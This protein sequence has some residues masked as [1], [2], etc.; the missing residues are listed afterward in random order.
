MKGKCMLQTVTILISLFLLMACMPASK[1]E[2]ENQFSQKNKQLLFLDHKLVYWSDNALPQCK[3][4]SLN[5]YTKKMIPD[6]M[7]FKQVNNERGDLVFIAASNVRYSFAFQTGGRSYSVSVKIE[8]EQVRLNVGAQQAF[9]LTANEKEK[10]TLGLTNYL[11]K[12]QKINRKK[13]SVDMI[14]WSKN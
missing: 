3:H 8:G 1:S 11:I 5:I 10:I 9:Y 14:I 6:S 13:K 4:C 7:L 12:L 2:I